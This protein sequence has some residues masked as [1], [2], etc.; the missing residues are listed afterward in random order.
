M[1]VLPNKIRQTLLKYYT[2]DI[3]QKEFVDW[4]EKE[5]AV[6]TLDPSDPEGKHLILVARNDEAFTYLLLAYG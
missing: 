1:K 5:G 3:S 4:L 6:F 2:Y